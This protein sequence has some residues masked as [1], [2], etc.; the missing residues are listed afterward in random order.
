MPWFSL[1]I[2]LS[3]NT[4][5]CINNSKQEQ[6]QSVLKKETLAFSYGLITEIASLEFYQYSQYSASIST[7]EQHF[8]DPSTFHDPA[9]LE[10]TP[11]PFGPCQGR[12]AHLG[13]GSHSNGEHLWHQPADEEHSLASC[14]MACQPFKLKSHLVRNMDQEIT[15]RQLHLWATQY[16]THNEQD[17]TGLVEKS[18]KCHVLG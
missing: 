7:G 17:L 18:N 9:S 1:M 15:W 12:Q 3:Q 16:L 8:I 5:Y 2:L 14:C 10:K 6:G 11:S 4:I 13:A